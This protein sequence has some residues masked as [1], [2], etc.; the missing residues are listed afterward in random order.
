MLTVI[1]G[2][3]SFKYEDLRTVL[4]MFNRGDYVLTF[5]LKFGYH[6]VDVNEEHWKYLGFCWKGQYYVFKVLPFGL[7]TACYVFT[8]LLRPLVR[9]W[10]SQGIRVVLYIDDGI[11]AFPS[12]EVASDAVEGIIR[13]IRKAGLTVNE[14]NLDL[15]HHSDVFGLDSFWISKK[16][17][18]L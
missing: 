11:I 15:F 13:D 3:A 18:S 6:H 7:S 12:L 10:R 17:R 2:S 5:D 8:K 9:Y 4:S 16:G 1:Y 14:K